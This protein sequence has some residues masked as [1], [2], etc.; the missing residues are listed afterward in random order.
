MT[1]YLVA[2]ATCTVAL[3]IAASTGGG[4]GVTAAGLVIACTAC[5]VVVGAIAG[6]CLL[7][8]LEML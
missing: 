6:N 2:C 7:N 4:A 1:L 5:V 3:A 8:C